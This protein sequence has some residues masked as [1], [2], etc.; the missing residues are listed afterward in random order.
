MH[1]AL[2]L[3]SLATSFDDDGIEDIT[4][5]MERGELNEPEESADEAPPL[6]AM[7]GNPPKV[8]FSGVG[9]WCGRWW[10]GSKV[11]TAKSSL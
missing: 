9:C 11:G 7:P 2:I 6:D 5:Q 1:T 10:C 3:C 8:A 4:M